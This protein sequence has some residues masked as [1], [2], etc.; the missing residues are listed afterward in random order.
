MTEKTKYSGMLSPQAGMM[1]LCDAETNNPICILKTDGGEIALSSVHMTGI[2]EA[3][4]LFWVCNKTRGQLLSTLGF[5]VD[6][7]SILHCLLMTADTELTQDLRQEAAEEAE[8]AFQEDEDLALRVSGIMYSKALPKE[9]DV[10]W[11]MV[12]DTK[13]PQVAKLLLEIVYMKGYIQ[14]VSGALDELAGRIARNQLFQG[15]ATRL[16]TQRDLV[17]LMKDLQFTKAGA[18]SDAVRGGGIKVMAQALE[19]KVNIQLIQNGYFEEYSCSRIL[20]EW[21]KKAHK[22][23]RKE[24]SSAVT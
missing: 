19:R 4:D 14:A 5:E 24:H 16:G 21:L 10:G 9:A 6:S 17:L 2:R 11:L 22:L 18:A 23:H 15:V 13:Y 1:Y 20:E 7:Q 3:S 12:K 8:E